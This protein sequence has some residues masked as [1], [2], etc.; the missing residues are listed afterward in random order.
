VSSAW[1]LYS[2]QRGSERESF[3]QVILRALSIPDSSENDNLT[4]HQ[5]LRILYLDQL[6]PANLLM[7]PEQFDPSTIREAVSKTL[8]GAYNIQ[9][10]TDENRYKEMKRSL[11]QYKAEIENIQYI[12]K[13]SKSHMSIEELRNKISADMERIKNIDLSLAENS[14]EKI[15]KETSKEHLIPYDIFQEMKNA[16]EK[17]INLTEGYNSF[18]SDIIDSENFIVELQQ[19]MIDLDN[20]I[21]MR[22][23]LPKLTISYCPVCLNPIETNNEI[24]ICPLC[25]KNILENTLTTNILRLK[26]E[27]AFQIKESNNLLLKKRK[28]IEAMKNEISKIKRQLELLQGH[29]D[30]YSI[31]VEQTEQQ[32]RDNALFLKG[33]LSKE[34]EYLN[35]ELLLQEQL[36]EDIRIS[37]NMKED[38]VEL[39]LVIERKRSELTINY[40]NAMNLIKK[41]ASELIKDDSER[42]LPK[43]RNSLSTLEIDFEKY[44]TFRLKGKNSFAASSMVY[45]KNSIMFAFLFASLELESM[46]HPRFFMCDNI[47]DKG[48]EEDRSHN[49]QTNI[50]NMSQKYKDVE[51]QIIITT[52][53]IEQTLDIPEI[54][55]GEA[56]KNDSKSLKIG[57]Q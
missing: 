31:S 24:D 43:D 25:K 11:D 38:L 55:I 28:Q 35:K 1:E 8:M 36:K 22:N 33:G 30:S 5:I 46:N 15:K 16:K 49:F 37:E 23:H 47:E 4:M 42:D 40:N 17:L 12:L 39:N 21:S 52:S 10:L 50:Y 13:H 7:R 57:A 34:I 2:M 18:T 14:K 32:K 56:Y 51:H 6:S 9:L 48:M 19:R 26:N 54:C 3:S 44:N 27:M 29:I 20:S 41:I 53:M 45:I